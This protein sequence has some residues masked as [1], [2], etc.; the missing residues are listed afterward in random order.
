[1]SLLPAVS[2]GQI[3]PPAA[4]TWRRDR[5]RQ[6]RPRQLYYPAMR[7]NCDRS[8]PGASASGACSWAGL[9]DHARALWKV[10]QAA[11]EY[12]AFTLSP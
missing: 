3:S 11:S 7:N 9:T 4:G 12:Q 6:S 8:T 2:G 5:T 10:A 1:M